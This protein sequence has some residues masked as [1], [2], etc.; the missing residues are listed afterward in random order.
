VLVVLLQV[1]SPGFWQVLTVSNRTAVT[2]LTYFLT[3]TAL[4]LVLASE[5]LTICYTNC[6]IVCLPKPTRFKNVLCGAK[7]TLSF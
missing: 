6:E 4:Q 7:L 2:S 3:S 1:L 5:A